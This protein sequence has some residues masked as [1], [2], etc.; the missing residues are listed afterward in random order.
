MM[1]PL[2]PQPK[3]PTRPC[4]PAKA[5]E[6]MRIN[7]ESPGLRAH[8]SCQHQDRGNLGSKGLDVGEVFQFV[9]PSDI[10]LQLPGAE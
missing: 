9:A 5:P 10:P 1:M 6:I 4:V 8:P 7:P 3:A 2:L